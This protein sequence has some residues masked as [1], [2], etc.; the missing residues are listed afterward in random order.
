MLK[1]PGGKRETKKQAI[2]YQS[3]KSI[4][5]GGKDS[6]KNKGQKVFLNFKFLTD[7]FNS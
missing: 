6:C 2:C 5:L 7:D 4:L 3:V 1:L